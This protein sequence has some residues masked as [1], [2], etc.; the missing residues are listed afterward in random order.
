MIFFNK[1]LKKIK[2]QEQDIEIDELVSTFHKMNLPEEQP[3]KISETITLT[4]GDCAENHR[5]MQEI[6]EKATI[7]L[8]YDDIISIQAFFEHRGSETELVSLHDAS[9]PE[10]YLL[11]ARKGCDA[12]VN[13]DKLTSEQMGLKRD[14][15]AFMYG[16][17]VNKI[18]RHNLCFSDFDQEP[19]YENKKGTV[20]SFDHLPYLSVIRKTLGDVSE[21]L[22]N[23]QCEANY[24]YDV[25]KTY[26]GFHGDT[27]RKIVV[28]VRLGKTFP[29]HFQWFQNSKPVGELFTRMLND[30]DMYFM[31]EKTVGFDW[32]L[33]KIPTLRHAAGKASKVVSWK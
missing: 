15:K 17:V 11:I 21:K 32:K 3:L 28:A 13:K 6:G 30:G 22:S 5:G 26:I 4:F 20:V 14:K 19:D 24:Y 9:K 1:I 12:I 31:S 33:K 10:A 25:A 8:T 7:G 29:I 18:A 2:M 27:E 16:R 23:L